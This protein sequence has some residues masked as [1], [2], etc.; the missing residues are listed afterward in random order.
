MRKFVALVG[1]ALA[2]LPLA[3]PAALAHSQTTAAQWKAPTPAA[4]ADVAGPQTIVV[5]TDFRFQSSRSPKLEVLVPSPD[6]AYPAWGPLS[7]CHVSPITTTKDRLTCDWDSSHYPD[8]RISVNGEYMLRAELWD[9]PGVL[10]SSHPH[11][12][13]RLVWVE[14]APADLTGLSRSFDSN[15]G[16]LTV[17]WA[18]NPE[19]DISRYVVQ[20]YNGANPDPATEQS[21]AGSSRCPNDPNRVCLIQSLSEPGTYRYRVAPVRYSGE[22]KD[23]QPLELEGFKWVD[24]EAF[25]LAAAPEAPRSTGGDEPTPATVEDPGPDP[26]VYIPT[27]APPTT[28]PAAASPAGSSSGS[29]PRPSTGG[30]SGGSLFPRPSGSF[31]ASPRATTTTTEYDPGYNDTLPYNLSRGTVKEEEEQAMPGEEVPQTI[32]KIIEIP[33]PRDTRALLVPLAGGLTIFVFAM[34]MTVLMRKRPAVATSQDD[35]NDWMGL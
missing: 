24:T 13:T 26:G 2:T 16:H 17:G 34:Q 30:A 32:E 10:G 4:N 3:A 11:V 29:A 12:I 9:D 20:R 6:R 25:D 18:P 27:D 23:G 28:A 8:G 14:N 35:F 31:S 5:D 1:L 22:M 33:R 7:A 21:V 15:T 19:P